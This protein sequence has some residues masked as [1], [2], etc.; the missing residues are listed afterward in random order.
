MKIAINNAFPLMPNTYNF[1]GS[2]KLSE[3]A[4]NISDSGTITVKE[5]HELMAALMD[6]S[7]STEEKVIIDRLI[8][9][10]RRGRLKL[11]PRQIKSAKLS[12]IAANISYSGTITATERHE[13][14]AA[15]M[16]DSLS[17][18]EKVIIDRLIYAYRRGRLKLEPHQIKS[19]Q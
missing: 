9:A 10:Y 18:E 5:R 3:I 11:E 19:A 14:M 13:L 2:A 12:E 6:D 4:A 8:Y 16:D 7:L 15:L 17:A 1:L